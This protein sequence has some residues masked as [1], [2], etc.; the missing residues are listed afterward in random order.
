MVL[1]LA[2]MSVEAGLSLLQDVEKSEI[3]KLF[4]SN[5]EKQS[6]VVTPGLLGNKLKERLDKGGLLFELDV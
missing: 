3:W 4:F 1:S 5:G 6:V 2:M